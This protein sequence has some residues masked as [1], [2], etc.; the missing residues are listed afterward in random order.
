MP[1]QMC[2]PLHGPRHPSDVEV[3]YRGCSQT[4]EWV[5]PLRGSGSGGVGTEVPF[6]VAA[7]VGKRKGW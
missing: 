4:L 6:R 2:Q 5:G 7:A 1:W 3:C